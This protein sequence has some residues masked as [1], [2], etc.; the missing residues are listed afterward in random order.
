MSFRTRP[1]GARQALRQSI[2]RGNKAIRIFAV[3]NEKR[4][5]AVEF[6]YS[7]RPISSQCGNRVAFF[8]T[9]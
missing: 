9:R 1:A 3:R 4:Q 2:T 7:A 8:E 6:P 5:T